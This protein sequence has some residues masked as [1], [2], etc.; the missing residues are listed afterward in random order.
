VSTIAAVCSASYSPIQDRAISQAGCDLRDS[1]QRASAPPTGEPRINEILRLVAQALRQGQ[2]DEG[3]LVSIDRY[4]QMI[5]FLQVLPQE[6]PV[7]EIVVESDNQIGLDWD[8]GRR[9]IVA[10]TLN[11]TGYIGYSA[12]VGHEA[13]HGRAPFAGYM[14]ETVSHLLQRLLSAADS[15]AG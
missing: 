1:I 13:I 6:V 2:K 9:R 15:S 7:P 8:R 11:E 12:L 14:P 10:L 5:E 4:R 3:A